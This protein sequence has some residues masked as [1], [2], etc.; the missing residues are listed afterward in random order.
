MKTSLWNLKSRDYP[1]ASVG[2]LAKRVLGFFII[3]VIAL[4]TLLSNAALATPPLIREIEGISEYR[5]PNGLQVLLLPDSAQSKVTINITYR[6]GS[7][8]EGRGEMGMAHLLEHMLFKG[9]THFPNVKGALQEKSGDYNATTWYDRTNYFETMP[10]SE[11]NVEFGLK[12]EAD[13]MVNSFIKKSDLDAEMTVVRNEFEMGEN[14]PGQVLMEKMM[15]VAFQWHNYGK[16]TIGNRSDIERVP[17][18]KL[19]GF[20]KKYYR[21]DNA[22]LLV[23]GKFDAP[24]TLKK[25]DSIFGAIPNPE[26]PLD[27]TYTEEPVQDGPR[28]VR[29]ER[30]GNVAVVGL[31]YHIPA[32]SHPDFMA[33]DLLAGM[34]SDAP[35]GYLYKALVQTKLVTD[36][37]VDTFALAEPGVMQ[38]SAKPIKANQADAIKQKL[39]SLMEK[40]IDKAITQ[41]A[42]NRAKTRALK[43]FKLATTDAGKFAYILSESIAQGDYRLFYWMREQLKKTTLADVRR[44]AKAYLI[45]SNRTAGVFIPTAKP[46]RAPKSEPANIEERVASVKSEADASAK[47]EF[48]ASI[49]NI[50]KTVV[51]KELNKNIKVAFL[52]K[53]TRNKKVMLQLSFRYGSESA[54]TPFV[55]E[56]EVLP[57]LLSRGSK[58]KSFAQVQDR[59][60]ELESTLYLSG[61]AGLV[62]ASITSD[63]DHVVDMVALLAELMKTPR[64]EDSELAVVKN[65]ALSDIE[66]ARQDPAKLASYMLRRQTQPWPK[67]SI[68]YVPTFDERTQFLKR[69]TAA[70]LVLLHKRFISADKLEVAAVGDFDEAELSS[71]LTKHFGNWHSKEAFKRITM[72]FKPAIG[73]NV[74]VKTPDKAMTS[75][76]AG[77]NLQLRDDDPDYAAVRMGD[78]LFGNGMKS[79]LME[80]LREKEGLSYGGGSQLVPNRFE[81]NTGFSMWAIAA[82]ENA[83]KAKDAM[84]EEFQRFLGKNNGDVTSIE[85]EYGKK[86]YGAAFQNLLANDGFL[87]GA[88]ANDLTIDRTFRYYEDLLSKINALTP[89]TLHAAWVRNVKEASLAVIE[90]G[91]LNDVTVK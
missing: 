81:K 55:R 75:L 84:M 72:P 50:E 49:E 16:T 45:E 10:A 26:T 76:R 15:A 46:V 19:Q 51:R 78:F 60:D 61:S 1:D 14:N 79:R 37:S 74:T 12:L 13:R 64:L 53:P 6:V 20:Y 90:A 39:I 24:S 35:S 25:I 54:L 67:T 68:H 88:L 23:A 3:A 17:I 32:A 36:L 29:L 86:A 87:V 38:V 41:E 43:L 69:L 34:L 48:E 66:E 59:T 9:S 11:A 82:N 30:T 42:L 21:P 5:L 77:C 71:A 65:E 58:S 70:K 40:S 8:H 89:E 57:A 91:D 7:R 62:Q 80:R 85:L 44:A 47:G 2:I 52:N 31:V 22:T 18:E 83:K 56:C 4:S 73:G 63:R 27:A 28:E 33:L